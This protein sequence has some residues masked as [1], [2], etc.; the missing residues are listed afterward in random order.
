MKDGHGATA[1]QIVH[2]GGEAHTTFLDNSLSYFQDNIECR[3]GSD[4]ERNDH[5]GKST[6]SF[7][8]NLPLY[9]FAILGILRQAQNSFQLIILVVCY[10][11]FIPTFT[12]DTTMATRARPNFDEHARFSP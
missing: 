7:Y 10:L 3:W 4:M 8:L 6:S 11:Y 9:D 1:I 5:D 2:I 12:Q